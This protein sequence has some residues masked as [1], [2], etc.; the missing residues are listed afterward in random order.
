MVNFSYETFKHRG[1]TWTRYPA[2]KADEAFTCGVDLGQS[3]DP[4]AIIVLHATRTSLETWTTNEIAH[5]IKQDMEEHFDVVHGER[6]KLGTSYP[7]IVAHVRD[8]L[9]RPPL[10]DG[11]ELVIDE[12]GVGRAVGDMFD[13]TG[14][15]PIR[16]SI[17][18]G[19]DAKELDGARRWS[20][21]KSLLISGVDARL[22][23]G[24]LRFAAELAEA[25][26]LA[27]ELK[28]FQRHLT[29]AGRA[30]YQARTGKHETSCWRSPSRCGGPS[31]G[32]DTRPTPGRWLVSIEQSR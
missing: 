7:E 16:V 23:S 29:S 24:E 27:E 19:T 31:S 5:T 18:A 12:S 11:C 26:A 9:A 15:Q 8:V 30:T 32:A 13:A 20:V 4:T 28:D 17:T 14:L 10:R 22:H 6:L 25:H 2:P 21:A 1:Q 3:M